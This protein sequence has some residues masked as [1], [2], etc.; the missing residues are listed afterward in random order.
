MAK[1]HVFILEVV[2]SNPIVN[3]IYSSESIKGNL[4]ISGEYRHLPL[5]LKCIRIDNRR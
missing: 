4:V 3:N 1:A 2:S 5:M